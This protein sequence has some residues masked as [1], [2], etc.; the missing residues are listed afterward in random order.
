M[1]LQDRLAPLSI[2]PIEHEL[3]I[4]TARSGQSWVENFRAVRRRE[5]DDADTRIKAV[6]IGQ[7]LVERLLLLVAPAIATERGTRS[8]ERVEFVNEDDA[9]RGLPGLL[10]EITH[11]RRANADEHLDKFRA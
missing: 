8:S 10:E 5:Q 7:E 4:E 6:E 3:T 9:G 1:D 11:A 2:G